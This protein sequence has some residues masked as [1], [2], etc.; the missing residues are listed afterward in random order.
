LDRAPSGRD[1]SWLTSTSAPVAAA[2]RLICRREPAGARVV[3]TL[4]SPQ[5]IRS[6]RAAPVRPARSWPDRRRLAS[7]RWLVP[8]VSPRLDQG[9][10]DL[11]DPAARPARRANATGPATSA[12]ADPGRPRGPYRQ[13][14]ASKQD[15]ESRIATIRAKLIS[16]TPPTLARGQYHGVAA[17]GWAPSTSHGP[18]NPCQDRA[19]SVNTQ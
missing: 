18:P 1:A 19:H 11:P 13:A 9:H 16:Q 15:R 14:G 2:S 7:A 10:R 4:L 12:T 6:A 8:L 17:T 5:T 3:P